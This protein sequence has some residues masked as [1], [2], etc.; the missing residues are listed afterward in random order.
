MEESALRLAVRA[1]ARKFFAACLFNLA[2]DGRSV[3]SNDPLGRLRRRTTHSLICCMHAFDRRTCVWG[4]FLKMDFEKCISPVS[5]N[6]KKMK[7]STRH[8]KKIVLKWCISPEKKSVVSN[9]PSADANDA[10]SETTHE[11]RLLPV[12]C[13]D[14]VIAALRRSQLVCDEFFLGFTFAQNKMKQ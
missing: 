12:R 2:N 13:T 7:N 11:R 3:A 10:Q 8:K 9:D 4:R 14:T 6:I 5:G 1:L